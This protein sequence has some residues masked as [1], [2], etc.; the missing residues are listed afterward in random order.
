[1]VNE[2]ALGIFPIRPANNANCL[3]PLKCSEFETR[4]HKGWDVF[5]ITQDAKLLDI[6]VRR[7]AGCHIHYKRN[8]GWQQAPRFHLGEWV[9]PNDYFAKKNAESAKLVKYPKEY[10]DKYKSAEI[11]TVK[12][13]ILGKLIAFAALVVAA[14][15]I[16][17]FAYS[18]I[19]GLADVVEL[20]PTVPQPSDD[21]SASE[22]GSFAAPFER[23][24]VRAG[25]VETPEQYVEQ[26]QP[27][28]ESMP[29]SAPIYD[30]VAK[31]Q[32]A[33]EIRGCMASQYRCVCYAQQGTPVDL[34]SHPCRRRI[35]RA[36]FNPFQWPYIQGK[37]HHHEDASSW[38]VSAFGRCIS[39]G[40]RPA[41][42]SRAATSRSISKV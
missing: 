12:K 17:S 32:A 4:R 33:P 2:K 40:G 10:F 41:V 3:V 26:W 30:G 29:W 36:E 28:V 11:H 13:R 38:T 7:L 42:G 15:G 20:A 14:V 6:H 1:M 27:R 5:L 35:V 22:G 31:V 9:D 24:T 25:R 39:F 23:L 21:A 16:G 37:G 8:V 18:K 19:T 34:E